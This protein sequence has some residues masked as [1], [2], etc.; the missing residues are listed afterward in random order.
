MT[1]HG[2]CLYGACNLSVHFS[3]AVWFCSQVAHVRAQ[4]EELR[5]LE[6]KLRAARVMRGRDVQVQQQK[7]LKEAEA[8][9]EREL[10]RQV[11]A[12]R[13]VL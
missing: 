12:A 1:V 3:Y 8:A 10:E 13:W 6:V 9:Y 11:E 2:I 7:A 4:S 5:R